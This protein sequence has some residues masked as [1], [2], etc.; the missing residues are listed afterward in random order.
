MRRILKILTVTAICVCL[1]AS[2]TSCNLGSLFSSGT[3][4]GSSVVP[5]LNFSKAKKGLKEAG[6]EIRIESQLTGATP[7]SFR[8]LEAIK[9]YGGCSAGVELTIIE[10]T[11]EAAA[12]VYFDMLKLNSDHNADWL[13]AKYNVYSHLKDN[14]KDDL[15]DEKY[16]RVMTHMGEC[17]KMIEEGDGDYV[18]GRVGNVVYRGTKDAVMATKN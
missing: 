3:R 11:G 10:F 13:L 15:S 5:E 8:V 1:L 6:Y 7:G 9:Y 12:E 14:H 17:E 4:E 2:L 16:Q 18:F